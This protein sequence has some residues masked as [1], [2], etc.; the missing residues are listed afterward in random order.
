[1]RYLRLSGFLALL[2]LLGGALATA[3]LLPE[4]AGRRFRLWS[5]QFWA[6]AVLRLTRLTLSEEAG[7]RTPGPHVI[8]ANHLSYLDI[9]VLM[10]RSPA[11]FLAKAEVSK[12]PL[13][14]QVGR[15]AGMIFVERRDLWKRA[16]SILEIQKRVQEGYDVVVFPEGTTSVEGPIA[17][18]AFFGGAFRVSRMEEVPLEFVHLEY[19]DEQACAWV[20]EQAFFPHFW[21][22]LA[23]PSTH[24]RI[25]SQR[26]EPVRCRDTQKAVNRKA[27]RWMLEGGRSPFTEASRTPSA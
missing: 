27:R 16:A 6:R 12:W 23:R 2:G 4:R 19:S 10:A 17:G 21:A 8:V 5:L 14:G 3:L 20:G 18:R 13:M 11:L 9:P 1:M 15:L 25:R 26:V 22:F 24:V 7:G